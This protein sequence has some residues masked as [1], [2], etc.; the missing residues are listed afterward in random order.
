MRDFGNDVVVNAGGGVHGHPM[1]AAAGGQA[2]R[3][4]IDAAL[5]GISLHDAAKAAGNEAL[6]AAVSAWGV[7]EE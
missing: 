7:R 4:A 6:G 1:G 3:Q 2:F 5:A